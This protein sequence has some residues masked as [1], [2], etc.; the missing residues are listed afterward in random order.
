[1]T[2]SPIVLLL[3]IMRR[4]ILFLMGLAH[5]FLL[6]SWLRECCV[7]FEQVSFFLLFFSFLF[8]SFF[9][10]FFSFL[11]FSFLSFSFSF[12][13]FSFLFFSFLFFSFFFLSFS[14]FLSQHSNLSGK[15]MNYNPPLDQSILMS[16]HS[17]AYVLCFGISAIAHTFSAH[18]KVFFPF[19]SFF[20]FSLLI[21]LSKH[22]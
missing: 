6:P 3:F 12:L 15:G 22:S 10:F 17:L 14:F 4:S 16:L 11:F 20:S 19:F 7:I 5:F 21:L 9:F 2:F 18:S 8:F 13:F 1:M